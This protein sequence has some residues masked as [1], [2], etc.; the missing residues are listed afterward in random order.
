M[1]TPTETTAP[2]SGELLILPSEMEDTPSHLASIPVQMPTYETEYAIIGLEA[3]ALT[4]TFSGSWKCAKRAF[5]TGEFE[6]LLREY[7]EPD[8]VAIE[9]RHIAYNEGYTYLGT[10]P[11][12]AGHA[13]LA[14]WHHTHE[15]YAEYFS[16][17]FINQPP[18]ELS[19]RVSPNSCR[20][21]TSRG[22]ER[23]RL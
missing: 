9:F 13:G 8:I 12:N 1:G 16:P 2:D 15:T 7:V 14:V 20:S 6:T 4:V 21:P 10:D 19:G 18:S 23:R 5:V 11:P 3:P 17:V 22:S